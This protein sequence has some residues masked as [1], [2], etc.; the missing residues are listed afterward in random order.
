M[1]ASKAQQTSVDA[2]YDDIQRMEPRITDLQNQVARIFRL[3]HIDEREAAVGEKQSRTEV[4]ESMAGL[5]RAVQVLSEAQTPQADL[6]AAF[7]EKSKAIRHRQVRA[8]V[9]RKI[10]LSTLAQ[11]T[12]YLCPCGRHM[13][14]K[15]LDQ[16]MVVEENLCPI[17]WWVTLSHVAFEKGV[18]KCFLKDMPMDKFVSKFALE[19]S[20][21]TLGRN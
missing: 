1:A 5:T 17:T 12:T 21:K 18:L 16:G 8:S 6:D 19:T 11:E 3:H 13:G 10:W 4:M 2:L 9:A 20:S 15:L 7:Y 14:V